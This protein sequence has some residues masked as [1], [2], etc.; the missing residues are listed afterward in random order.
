MTIP[1]HQ[2]QE[3]EEDSRVI[4]AREYL[5][6]WFGIDLVSIVPFN[7]IMTFFQ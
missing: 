4:I 1:K 2:D 5:T 6:G 7:M 3:K